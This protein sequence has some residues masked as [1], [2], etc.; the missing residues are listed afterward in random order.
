MREIVAAQVGG[1]ITNDLQHI[2]SA[3]ECRTLTNFL[4]RQHMEFMAACDL[5]IKWEQL[6]KSRTLFIIE[7][8]G[9]VSA[10]KQ[11]PPQ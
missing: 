7:D 2:K 9:S 8:D 5:G 11:K 6:A 3:L 1:I 10:P 4:C